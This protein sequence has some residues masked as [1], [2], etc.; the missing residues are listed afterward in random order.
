VCPVGYNADCRAI[1]LPQ[2]PGIQQGSSVIFCHCGVSDV[3]DIHDDFND[4][5]LCDAD[6]V[7]DNFV[8]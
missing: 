4:S 3:H 7:R 6:G 1:I 2:A 5:N 8:V